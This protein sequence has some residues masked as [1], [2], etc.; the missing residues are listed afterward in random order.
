MDYTS[1]LPSC[2]PT[3]VKHT[4]NRISWA[5][6]AE[7]GPMEKSFDRTS[8]KSCKPCVIDP[9]SSCGQMLY[10]GGFVDS[11]TGMMVVPPSCAPDCC[12][13]GTVMP[14]NDSN[15]G[16]II[17]PV[18]KSDIPSSINMFIVKNKTAILVFLALLFSIILGFLFLKSGKKTNSFMF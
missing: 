11:D 15:N 7:S 16:E 10:G 3:F 8:S 13:P 4:D 14:S 12:K 18:K 17:T 9:N 2:A 5:E 6:C 1:T